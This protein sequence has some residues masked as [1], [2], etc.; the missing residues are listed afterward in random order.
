MYLAAV[1]I[2][3]IAFSFMLVGV[4]TVRHNSPLFHS[5]ERADVAAKTPD[6]S[7]LQRPWHTQISHPTSCGAMKRGHS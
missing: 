5:E 6:A 4:K 1:I 3:N 2:G 7:L